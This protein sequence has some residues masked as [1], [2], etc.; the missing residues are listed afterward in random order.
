MNQLER[1]QFAQERSHQ[2]AQ[3]AMAYLRDARTNRLNGCDDLAKDSLRCAA[4]FRQDALGWHM[5]ARR[6]QCKLAKQEV[7]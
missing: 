7:R 1:M 5:R 4:H 3:A 6:A 2:Y